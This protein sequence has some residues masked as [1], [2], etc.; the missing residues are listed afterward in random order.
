VQKKLLVHCISAASAFDSTYQCV[1][2]QANIGRQLAS[3]QLVNPL[4]TSSVTPHR[5]LCV[6][7]LLLL[8][9]LLVMLYQQCVL[10]SCSTLLLLWWLLTGRL[11]WLLLLLQHSQQE[12]SCINIKEGITNVAM[13]QHP[14]YFNITHSTSAAAAV[15]AAAEAAAAAAAA[16]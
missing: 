3:W 2:L 12:L 4:W 8:L 16:A 5:L 15:G 6:L 10:L 13:P 9:L 14:H 7:L 1:A 11:S